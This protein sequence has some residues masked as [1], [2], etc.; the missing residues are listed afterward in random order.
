MKLVHP[1]KSEFGY[2][3]IQVMDKREK[4][5][6]LEDKKEE[7]RETIAATKGDLNTKI[8]E[9]IKEAKVDVKDADLKDAFSTYTAT[10]EETTE[11]EAPAEEESK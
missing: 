2:H 5:T 4:I 3:I 8:A 6:V 11:T 10:P 7:I 1:V 9:L